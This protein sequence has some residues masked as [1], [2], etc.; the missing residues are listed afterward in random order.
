M[1][2]PM[3]TACI[4]NLYKYAPTR[5][6]RKFTHTYTQ[7]SARTHTHMCTHTNWTVHAK[8]GHQKYSNTWRFYKHYRP[9][10]NRQTIRMPLFISSFF[11]YHFLIIY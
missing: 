7:A 5:E 6:L 1:I 9:F 3:Y 10:Y 2:L 4:E 11:Y 8:D